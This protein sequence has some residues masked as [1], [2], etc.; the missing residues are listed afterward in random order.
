[1]TARYATAAGVTS[2]VLSQAAAGLPADFVPRQ[3]DDY[4]RVTPE[5][6]S[7]VAEELLLPQAATLVVVGDAQAL[8]TPLHEAGFDAEVRASDAN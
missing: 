7:K 6:A 3:L 2:G 5:A 4:T 8:L 1:M